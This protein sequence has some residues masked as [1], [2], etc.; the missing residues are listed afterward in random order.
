VNPTQDIDKKYKML[1]EREEDTRVKLAEAR[2]KL[3]TARDVDVEA[4]AQAALA[5]KAAPKRTEVALRHKVDDLSVLLDGIDTAVW[6]LQLEARAAVGEGRS[7]PIFIPDNVPA[8]REA[9]IADLMAHKNRQPDESDEDFE[10]RCTREVPR[11]ERDAEGIIRE[12][13]RQREISLDRRLPRLTE[14]PPVL[15]KWIEAAYA[16]EDRQAESNYE[17]KAKKARGRAAVEAVNRA[18]AEH[19][20]RGLPSGSFNMR[21]YPDIVLPEHLAEFEQQVARSPFQKAREQLPSLEEAQN[22]PVADAQPVNEED[23][24][25]R[26]EI[27]GVRP[28]AASNVEPVT[29]EAA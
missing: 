14:R 27:A 17:A 6:H 28:P 9:I 3:K 25:R 15:S 7:F 16:A 19:Q 13:H 22:E 26:R 18:K 10:A 2:E 21:A 24:F 8:N 11:G 5:G 20:R 23:A 1:L 4:L 12:A 29:E